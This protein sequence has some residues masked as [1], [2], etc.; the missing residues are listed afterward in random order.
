VFEVY[1][2]SAG[3]ILFALAIILFKTLKGKLVM[4]N[5]MVS[6]ITFTSYA[7]MFAGLG[8]TVINGFNTYPTRWLFYAASCSFLMYEVGLI[9]KKSKE[10]LIEMISLNILVMITGYLASITLGINQ[11]IFL[12]I[13]TGCFVKN[14]MIINKTSRKSKFMK[15]VINYVSVTWSLFPITWLLSP[16]FFGLINSFYTAV[17]YLFLDLFTKVIFGYITVRN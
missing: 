14:L 1:V 4:P 3:L 5:L 15:R 17:C 2:F 12:V 11:L 9:L 10:E 16:V 8:L 6:I 7:V 13:S